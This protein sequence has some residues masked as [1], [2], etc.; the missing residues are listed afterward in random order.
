MTFMNYICT[1]LS[2]KFTSY[3]MDVLNAKQGPNTYTHCGIYPDSK[4]NI[5]VV[6]SDL[7][8]ECFSM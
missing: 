8:R 7:Y 3:D 5:I 2:V 6:L 1:A 4:L